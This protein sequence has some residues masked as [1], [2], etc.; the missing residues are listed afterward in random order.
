MKFKICFMAI[1]WPIL[2]AMAQQ[3]SPLKYRP[4]AIGDTVP[5]M[6]IRHLINYPTQTI[7]LSDFKGKLLI[8]DFWAT[9]CSPCVA[10]FPKMDS[11]RKVFGNKLFILPVT[12]QDEKTV[13]S[14]LTNMQKVKGL[15]GFSVVRDTVLRALFKHSEIPHYVWINERGIVSAVTDGEQ[16]NQSN[17]QKFLNKEPLTFVMKNDV[18]RRFDTKRPLN[19]GINAINVE[20]MI[21][22]RALTRHV[23]G[24]TPFLSFKAPAGK[25]YEILGLNISAQRLYQMAYGEFWPSFMNNFNRMV[26]ESK[27]SVSIKGPLGRETAGPE[28][29]GL[30][31]KQN[32]YCYQLI[33]SPP[34]TGN[35]FRYMREDLDRQFPTL[36]ASIAKKKGK[37]IV[38]ISLDR[39]KLPHTKGGQREVADNKYSFHLQNAPWAFFRSKLQ[40]YY[41]QTLTTPLI[42]ETGIS[43]NV[44][45][46]VIANMSNIAELRTA[47]QKYGIDI[48]EAER[49]ID[50]IVIKD[51]AASQ[52]PQKAINVKLP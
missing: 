17:I 23:E 20:D 3:S 1:L 18:K 48:I 11:L 15:Q 22:Y 36:Q 7:R 42:D 35:I 43:G 33:I 28:A 31:M 50:M 12:D 2:S 4:L 5:D 34:D 38:M 32:T 13:S 45:L 52:V 30:W 39:G 51:R 26:I 16:V 21:N 29:W 8:L 47:L 37:S 19:A 44:D 40:T 41:L 14:L 49:D 24:F 6:E 27:D 10:S 25:P 9:W 46:D